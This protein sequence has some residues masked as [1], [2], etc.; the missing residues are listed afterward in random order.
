MKRFAIMLSVVFGLVIVGYTFCPRPELKTFTTYSSAWFDSKERLLRISLAEDE[1]YRLFDTLAHLSPEFIAATVLY[2]DQN[3]YDHFGV[4]FAALLRAFW[5]TYILDERRVGAS[6]ITMQVARLRWQIPSRTITGKLQQI[7]RAIQLSRHYTKN[8]ILQTYFNFAPYGRN[9]E[10]VAAASLI[11]FNKKPS[12]LSLPEALTLAVIPQNPNKR[13]PTTTV[14]FKHLLVARQNL[15]QRWL[16][17]HPEDIDQQTFFAMPL[18][19]R[20]PEELPFIAPHFVNQ[21]QQSMSRWD[22]GYI[23]T[24]LDSV[25]QTQLENI[26]SGYIRAKSTIG[27]KNAAALL[28]NYQTMEVKAMVGSADFADFSLQGQVN[29][30]TAKR[31]P[32]STLKPF[33]YG[34]AIDEGLIHPM[35]LMKDAPKRFAGFSPENYDKQFLG[36]VSARDALI[37]SRNVPAVDLQS[38][39]RQKSF[40]QFLKD[41]GVTGLKQQSHYGLALALGGG[42]V[43]MQELVT[44]YAALANLGVRKDIKRVSYIN[45]VA[46]VKSNPGK[47]LLSAEASF[48]VLDM[49][50]DNPAPDALNFDHQSSRKNQVAWKTGTSW[51][52]R[53]AWAI[54]VSGPYVLAVWVGN[55]DGSGNNA[56]VGRSAAGPLL[57]SILSAMLRPQ[58]WT[59]EGLA[60]PQTLN[61]KKLQVCKASGDL[62]SKHCPQT[63]ESWF[64]PGVSPIKVSNIYRSIPIERSSGK[65]ACWYQYGTTQMQTFEFWPSDFLHIFNQAGISL[66]TPPKYAEQC[67][68]EQKSRAGLAPVITSP[69]QSIEYVIQSDSQSRDQ[70]IRQI[71]FSAIVE[72]DVEVLH[73]FVNAQYVG[74]SKR[75]QTFIWQAT[76]GEHVVRVVDDLGRSASKVIRVLQIR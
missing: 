12:Q 65:R 17:Y 18:H 22:Q 31:S 72:P 21:L 64:I 33:V 29:G 4:D 45:G 5:T 13:N 54:G 70:A 32:G 73:W 69:Q 16:Q 62:A 75:G 1:R 47:R 15:Y 57:F 37:K 10:G 40:Y 8:E 27:I 46:D 38:Q 67:S 3:F 28:V 43:S 55:F 51:A 2:E 20:P 53:D 66:K 6:T 14:G 68:L 34:L 76:N 74:M 19:V 25:Q 50:K 59:I 23:K 63:V 52:F 7:L 71:P 56:F 24:T 36:P 48:M 49:L 41:A 61:L 11:Y 39:L 26:V 9:I 60:K 30:V 42:E 35:T 44:L 58:S